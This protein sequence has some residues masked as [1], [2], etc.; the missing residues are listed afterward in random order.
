MRRGLLTPSNTYRLNATQVKAPGGSAN[1]AAGRVLSVSDFTTLGKSTPK[2]L[3]NL[4]STSDASGNSVT[5][6]NG[7]AVSFVSGITGTSG[8]AAGFT[9]GTTSHLSAPN[10]ST[11]QTYGSY[12]C[13][14]KTVSTSGGQYLMSMYKGTADFTFG[15]NIAS[16]GYMVANLS[17]SGSDSVYFYS[18]GSKKV[19]D[20][21][22]HFAVM[23]WNGSDLVIYVDGEVDSKGTYVNGS[24]T[25]GA[26]YQSASALFYIGGFEKDATTQRAKGSIDEAFITSDVLTLEDVRFLYA[27][28]L[29]HACPDPQNIRAQVVRRLRSSSFTSAD[30]ST[31]PLV[32]YNFNSGSLTTDNFG[33]VG[34][35]LTNN[36]TVTEAPDID[37]KTT[38][39][40]NFNGSNQYFSGTDTSLPSGTSARSLGA[41]VKLVAKGTSQTII[42]YGTTSGSN[43]CA[44]GIDGEGKAYIATGASSVTG[45]Q[46]GDNVWHF[47]VGVFDNSASDGNK[48]KLYIDGQLVAVD[49]N[50]TSTTLGGANKLTIGTQVGAASLYALGQMGCAFITN[51]A[52]SS[53]EIRSLYNKQG[54]SYLKSNLA[55]AAPT[56]TPAVRATRSSTQSI[57]NTT[58]TSVLFTATDYDTDNLHSTQSNTGRLTIRTPGLYLLQG[59]LYMGVSATGTRFLRIYKNGATELHQWL[60]QP[61]SAGEVVAMVHCIAFLNAGDYVEMQAY[62]SSGGAMNVAAS[63]PNWCFF[64]AAYLGS[65]VDKEPLKL[66][67]WLVGWDST[68]AYTI[69]NGKVQPQDDVILIVED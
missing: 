32:G 34:K 40:A 26:M 23:T 36:N 31:Q 27:S 16:S 15:L 13:W 61:G 11:K 44:I 53:D 22:W 56:K 66:P 48:V 33:S 17:T 3:W 49:T 20:D 8:E 7:G 24:P 14:F 46:A 2:A 64:E 55:V 29:A 38:G 21:Q 52:I 42:E 68:Y 5:L 25:P 19:D 28:R 51:Y 43:T 9:G 39:A 59:S 57:N 35:T 41:W 37:G 47:I 60:D 69:F 58:W 50:F 18:Q 67:D 1:V 30:F 63:T 45:G 4:G 10:A 65:G 6:T 12:G 62:Q 54:A